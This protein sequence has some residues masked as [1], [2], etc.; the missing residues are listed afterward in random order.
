MPGGDGLKDVVD[1]RRPAGVCPDARL[2]EG[3]RLPGAEDRASA[4]SRLQQHGVLTGRDVEMGGDGCDLG[5]GQGRVQL[6][7]CHVR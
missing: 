2:G 1:R 4:D 5:D 7:G 3:D 6:A